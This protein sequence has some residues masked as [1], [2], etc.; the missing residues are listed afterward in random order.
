M[1]GIKFFVNL[2]VKNQELNTE[3]KTAINE[4]GVFKVISQ[5]EKQE[6][7]LLICE[8]GENYEEELNNLQLFLDK[9]DTTEIFLVSKRSDP[10]ILIQALRIGIKEFFPVPLKPELIKDALNRF[11]KR[12]EKLQHTTSGSSGKIYSILG[13]KG[14]VGT[15]TVAVNLAVSIAV[16]QENPSVALLDMNII[17]GDVPILLDISPK[18]NWGDITQNIERLDEFFLANILTEHATGVHVLPS[19]RYLNNHP[20]PTPTI[21]ETLLDLMKNKY[22][23]IIIDLGQSMNETALRI[24]QMSDLVHVIAIQSLPCLSNTN[25]LV[26]SI[27]EYGYIDKENVKIVLN[28]YLKK[29]MVSLSSAEEGVGKK[30]SWVIPNDYSTTMSAINS[31][32][33]LYQVAQKSRIVKSFNDYVEKLLGVENIKRKKMWFF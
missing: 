11:K 28:R 18:H 7:D 15:T 1:P 6:P 17:F 19:P 9:A 4:T 33:P 10:E 3:F 20:S 27:V 5:E 30:L 23:Y 16:N 14:G 32:K 31:G 26:N 2:S 13:S 12:Y 24:V 21:M 29:G 8:L 22:D 25:R